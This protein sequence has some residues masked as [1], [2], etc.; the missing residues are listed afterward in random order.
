MNAMQ[1]RSVVNN[2]VTFTGN[3]LLKYLNFFLNNS[4]RR[5][6]W[7]NRSIAYITFVTNDNGTFYRWIDTVNVCF[8]AW[9]ALQTSFSVLIFISFE[10]EKHQ[11]LFLEI[12][13]NA[14]NLLL[15]ALYM[16]SKWI[17]VEFK[18]ENAA[19][20]YLYFCVWMPI[21]ST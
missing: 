1:N 21:G 7:N 17:Y 2:I 18:F 6:N 14:D 4:C 16:R 13:C 20:S 8:P 12:S 5:H 10:L 19:H 15:M 11:I 3:Q 9:K